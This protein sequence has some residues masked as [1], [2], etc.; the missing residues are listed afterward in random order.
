MFGAHRKVGGIEKGINLISRKFTKNGLFIQCLRSLNAT[1]RE[2]LGPF[3]SRVTAPD[4]SQRS[5][6]DKMSSFGAVRRQL[7]SISWTFS[8]PLL[9]LNVRP[10]GSSN[11]AAGPDKSNLLSTKVI[12][13]ESLLR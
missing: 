8:F 6:T 13:P 9:N 12:H 11:I 10:L 4:T 1:K 2:A 7:L 3:Q 5:I